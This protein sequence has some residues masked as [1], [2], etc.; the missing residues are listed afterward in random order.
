M[1]E[2]AQY[3]DAIL[4][5]GQPR[6]SGSYAFTSQTTLAAI[7]EQILLC[8]RG[9]QQEYAGKIYVNIDQ[10]RSSVFLLTAK[11]LIPETLSVDETQIKANANLYTA[12]F[13]D[14]N[15]P[16]VATVASISMTAGVGTITISGQN[17]IAPTDT[18]SIGGNSAS[19]LNIRYYVTAVSGSTVSAKG[20][21]S[22]VTD[23]GT[24]G[25]VGYMQSRFSKRAPYLLHTQHALA[26]GQLSA[27]V[28]NKARKK[29]SVTLD[30]AN[31][32]FDQ[33]NRLLKYEIYRD[34][35]LDE[36]P[37][38]PPIQ[39]TLNAWAEAV[40]ASWNVLKSA[41]CGDV[42]TIDPTA[43]FEFAGEYEIIER[44]NISLS[45]RCQ[46]AHDCGNGRQCAR[47]RH[48]ADAGGS[49][50]WLHPVASSHL[51]RQL[52]N[53]PRCF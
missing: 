37:W 49:E 33:A 23:S 9:Y 2:A 29:L 31:M 36:V 13:L 5:N 8:C 6:F 46:H 45:G 26:E 11:H 17:P 20:V 10:P 41:Q 52:G 22:L 35:G 30:F 19:D 42:I 7:H 47:Q 21:G 15:L 24:G 48:A 34:L 50:R 12:E 32:S 44:K 40:D 27:A 38:K 25:T 51:Q 43:S 3:C 14:L 18:I 1:Y 39:I 53:L 4:A 28:S 16:A